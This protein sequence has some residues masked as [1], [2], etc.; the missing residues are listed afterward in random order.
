M[1]YDLKRNKITIQNERR[2]FFKRKNIVRLTYPMMVL[3]GFV[4]MVSLVAP[5]FAI[6]TTKASALFT[7][8]M[9]EDYTLSKGFNAPDASPEHTVNDKCHSFLKMHYS[10]DAQKVNVDHWQNTQRPVG[11]KAAPVALSLV[12]GVRIALGPKETSEMEQYIQAGPEFH[13]NASRGNPRA[14]AIAAFRRCK[15]E[16]TLKSQR[17]DL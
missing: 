3:F 7:G 9:R 12:L 8:E 4:T 10:P 2:I 6:D 13:H 14:L 11:R 15:N 16:A 1:G 17:R 5:A